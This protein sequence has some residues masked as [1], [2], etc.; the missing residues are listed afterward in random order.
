MEV[1]Q[2][3]EK[4]AE[5]KPFKLTLAGGKTYDVPHPDY[6]HIEPSQR[7][8]L[9]F[10]DPNGARFDVADILHISAIEGLVRADP[11]NIGGGGTRP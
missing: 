7:C 3:R 8:V 4:I 2:L 1:I 6:V 9:V 11:I 10:T 5:G